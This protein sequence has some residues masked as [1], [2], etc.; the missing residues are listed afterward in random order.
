MERVRELS[1]PSFESESVAGGA[2]ARVVEAGHSSGPAEKKSTEKE[3]AKFKLG[4]T[5]PVVPARL[6]RRILRGDYVDMSDLMP[7]SMDVEMRRAAGE[8]EPKAS[9]K[10][11]RKVVPDIV[12]W[13]QCFSFFAAV[14]SSEY[15]EK[16]KDLWAYQAMMVTAAKRF[17]GDGWRTYDSSFRQRL[18][19]LEVAEFGKLDHAI[20]TTTFLAG[21]VSGRAGGPS[22]GSDEW[23]TTRLSR[24]RETAADRSH[25]G[26]PRPKRRKLA[27]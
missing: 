19:S 5:L 17:G 16:A 13:A 14:V 10:A 12:T 6:V 15:P 25:P 23:T 24:S 20:Y 18:P 21:G 22:Q 2:G 3:T 8:E 11:S 26:E 27:C 4:D 1:L 7:E 9:A